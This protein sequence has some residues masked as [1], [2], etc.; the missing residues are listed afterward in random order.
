MPAI[1]G[2]WTKH[3]DLLCLEDSV[4]VA[5]EGNEYYYCAS[6]GGY[7]NNYMC[8][9]AGEYVNIIFFSCSDLNIY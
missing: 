9:S 4:S 5:G 8:A 3:E 7:V 1:C 2:L 6:V